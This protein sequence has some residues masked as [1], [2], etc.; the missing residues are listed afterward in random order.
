MAEEIPDYEELAKN[1]NL[2]NVTSCM[3]NATILRML[4]DGD[5]FNFKGLD[6]LSPLVD[7]GHAVGETLRFSVGERDDLGWLGYFIGKSE[8]EYLRIW[9]L[10]E[11]RSQ[12]NRFFQGM[13]Q[14]RSIRD[15]HIYDDIGIVGWSRLGCFLENHRDL[16]H[17]E[18]LSHL[19]GNESA[20]NL[21]L[22][23]GQMNGNCLTDLRICGT[24][25]DD[26]EFSQIAAALG[27]QPQLETLYLYE[28]NID[29]NSCIA[30]GNTLRRWPASNKLEALHIDNNQIDD[31]G[32]QA[33]AEGWMNCSNLDEI[34]LNDNTSII[35]AG[36][37]YLS[38]LL[39]SEAHRLHVLRVT[40]INWGDDGAI[41]L[42]EGLR[43][44]ESLTELRFRPST[45]GMT[46]TGWSAFSN[47]LCD[48]SSINSIYFSNHKVQRIGC[49]DN[50]E[51]PDDVQC[52]LRA[53][54][55]ARTHAA[56]YKIFCSHPDL[57][58]EPFFKLK[59]KFLPAVIS[60]FERVEIIEEE[61]IEEDLIQ[62]SERSC[63]SRKLS[64][65]FKFVRGMPALTADGYWEGRL[66]EIEARKR[67]IA[68]ERR[69]LDDEERTLK[70]EEQ[71]ALERS[72]P[73]DEANRNKR[74]RYE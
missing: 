50:E 16:L 42:A 8:I 14:N 35:A 46:S 74:T 24:G 25:I 9:Y 72:R 68:D 11:G 64:A 28:N 58:M 73:M 37:R 21:A 2:D 22:A 69:R 44:N 40:R 19:N 67:R 10:H 1:T 52:Y 43:G 34:Y 13:S 5:A 30:L 56:V 41:A 55:F 65:L 59:M 33:L 26:E 66:I 39:Q 48:T 32:L 23:L 49:Y 3:N 12:I 36:L 51:T 4:R 54:E 31:R 6:I 47:L 17:L 45:A 53:N 7:A 71:I 61:L 15:L 20:Q 57:D 70:Y 60:W 63:Q 29:R 38:P 62:E 27:S 18:V